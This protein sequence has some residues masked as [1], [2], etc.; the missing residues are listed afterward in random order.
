MNTKK[1]EILKSMI[2]TPEKYEIAID[3]YENFEEIG[4]S[5]RKRFFD[6]IKQKIQER[7]NLD[8]NEWFFFYENDPSF[9][10][11]K[12]SWQLDISQR[13]LYSF[14]LNSNDG[15]GLVRRNSYDPKEIINE[16]QSIIGGIRDWKGMHRY[17]EGNWWWLLYKRPNPF[18][19][20]GEDYRKIC[21]PESDNFKALVEECVMR[22]VE[23]LALMED[24]TLEKAIDEAVEL[25]KKNNKIA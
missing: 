24:T 14:C 16:E 21:N 2:N 23:L 3:I 10:L 7:F 15:S 25:R 6:G 20:S 22:M 1:V 12:R 17:S 11:F 13:G 4:Q 19:W 9:Y 8:E 18:S 5:R